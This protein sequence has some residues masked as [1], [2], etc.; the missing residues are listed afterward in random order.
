MEV[1]KKYIGVFISVQLSIHQSFRIAN[2]HNN[3][4]N[5]LFRRPIQLINSNHTTF[6]DNQ[7]FECT[8]LVLKS[9]LCILEAKAFLTQYI[10][11]LTSLIWPEHRS[12]HLSDTYATCAT[13]YGT[14][15][16]YVSTLILLLMKNSLTWIVTF[17]KYE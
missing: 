15:V 10:Q 14:D 11:L 13:C 16:G 6:T 12:C 17:K 1:I 4:K 5:Y 2:Y 9:W 8:T 7:P 3:G